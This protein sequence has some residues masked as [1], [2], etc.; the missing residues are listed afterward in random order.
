MAVWG[1]AQRMRRLPCSISHVRT[2]S[3]ATTHA[4]LTVQKPKRSD[5]F[6]ARKTLVR[7]L[8]DHSGNLAV[9]VL[10]IYGET[11]A[12]PCSRDPC[13]V[14]IAHACM[15]VQPQMLGPHVQYSWRLNQV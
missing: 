3:D 6:R 14:D 15:Y 10:L 9:S 11:T 13:K 12:R 8:I 2:Q 4:W 5:S 1:V 7:R